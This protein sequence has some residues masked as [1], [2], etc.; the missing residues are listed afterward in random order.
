MISRFFSLCFF[1]FFFS[2]F[3]FAIR[4]IKKYEVD[5]RSLRERCAINFLLPFFFQIDINNFK[6]SRKECSLFKL[7]SILLHGIDE[8]NDLT[9]T[10]A[11]FQ[12]TNQVSSHFKIPLRTPPFRPRFHSR[13]QKEGTET[14]TKEEVQLAF[15]FPAWSGN[16]FPM[17]PGPLEGS[18]RIAGIDYSKGASSS[19]SGIV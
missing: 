18:F 19:P 3:L 15:C 14:K 10:Y 7:H 4:R 9:C 6:L 2:F 16:D 5:W 13:S 17:I 11:K 8:Y 1:F 12:T